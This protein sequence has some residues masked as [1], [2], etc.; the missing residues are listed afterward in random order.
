[1]GKLDTEIKKRGRGRPKKDDSPLLP[2]PPMVHQRAVGIDIGV[3]GVHVCFPRE[4]VKISQW[5]VF[6]VA[7]ESPSWREQILSLLD[8][9]TV[10]TA[11]PT[12][13]HYLMPI[14]RVITQ[15]SP[16]A[17]WLVEHSATGSWRETSDMKQKT[18]I[19]DARSLAA[20]ADKIYYTH[21][22]AGARLLDWY[23]QEELLELRFMMNS[24]H[25]LKKEITRHKNRLA[26]LGHS[27]D[28]RLNRGNAW[29]TCMDLG[30][31]TPNEILDLNLIG[32][33][34][35]SSTVAA[36]NRLKADMRPTYVSPMLY[37]SL[38]ENYAELTRLVV[39]Q[40]QVLDDLIMRVKG[41]RWAWLYDVWMTAPRAFP[42]AV[43]ALIIASKGRPDELQFKVFRATVGMYP[44][45]KFSG[46]KK[47]S[48]SA[49]RGYRPAM[50]L[51]HMWT[52]S[53]LK[54]DTPDNL[55][56]RYFAGGESKGG[57]K[58]SA[59]KARFLRILHGMAKSRTPYN[60]MLGHEPPMRVQTQQTIPTNPL[61]RHHKLLKQIDT[62]M[63]D[64][65]SAAIQALMALLNQRDDYA[66]NQP[67]SIPPDETPPPNGT[68]PKHPNGNRRP[69]SNGN[70]IDAPPGL[71]SVP[72]GEDAPPPKRG[73]PPKR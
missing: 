8:S 50:A 25:K 71:D 34:L 3:D 39:Q 65:D 26:H 30:A 32:L 21:E 64:G 18:D 11:E 41:S 60:P 56:K 37:R 14:A 45:L 43:I 73:R 47:Q 7:Y 33:G 22:A 24:Y 68:R 46:T 20:I 59:T 38:V 44:V 55:I 5:P 16:A 23:E 9:D 35:S 53:L 51:M 36:I 15:E 62:L 42:A 31:Y 10:V 6:F 61:N 27:I 13:W 1:M 28:P 48:K 17:L 4:D 63:N 58:F 52:Q 54:K 49:R 66:A 2:P 19:N 72:L 12:G 67:D 69:M 70:L 29:A 57:R 40:N